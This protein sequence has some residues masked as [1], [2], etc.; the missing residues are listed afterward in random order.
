MVDAVFAPIEATLRTQLED[1]VRRCLARMAENFQLLNVASSTTVD[2]TATPPLPGLLPPN[3]PYNPVP[4]FPCKM[5]APSMAL[6]FFREPPHLDAE[7]SASA[8]SVA[9]SGQETLPSSHTDSGYGSN[10]CQCS[11][12]LTLDVSILK[13]SK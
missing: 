12:H 9:N 11:C 7:A 5:V 1:I 8:P 6:D 3:E 10:S 13:N 2:T 4:Q